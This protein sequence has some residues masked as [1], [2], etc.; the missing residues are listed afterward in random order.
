MEGYNHLYNMCKTI[1]NQS[2]SGNGFLNPITPRVE[3]I[4][5]SLAEIGVPY[6]VDVFS[7][8]RSKNLNE[9]RKLV[10]V[11]VEFNSNI[12]N[13]TSIMFTA[14]HDIAN[15][16]SENCQDNTA[17]VC[18]LIELCLK[19]SQLPVDQLTHNVIVAFT[20]CEEVGGKGI[21][22]VIEQIENYNVLVEQLYA[23]ELTACGDKYWVS[24]I[25]EQNEI[26]NHLKE[27]I[28]GGE[29]QIVSTPY[30]ESVNARRNGINACCIGT[31]TEDE[32]NVV[33]TQRYCST[34]GLCHS[35]EDTF[36]RSANEKDM[37][38]FVETLIKIVTLNK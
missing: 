22:R 37:E 5:N 3:Y 20:D 17:S 12:D 18:N 33:L 10:N 7:I 14:H 32:L 30:N 8:E 1:R 4:I 29:L 25:N 6:M 27:C 36:E 31:L 11:V 28:T 38:N 9:A 34:W 24:G 21:D 2:H 16:N 19:L 15:P 26:F 35:K 23:L 13:A